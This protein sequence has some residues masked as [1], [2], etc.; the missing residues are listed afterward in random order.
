M[1]WV[2]QN[3]PTTSWTDA[4]KPSTTWSDGVGYLLTQALGYL[5]LEDGGRI[6]LDQSFNNKPFTNWNNLNK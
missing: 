6:L 3:K 2:N 5:L 4:T 1:S